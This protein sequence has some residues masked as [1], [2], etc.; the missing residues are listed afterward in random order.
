ML[1]ITGSG[2][3]GTSVLARFCHNMGY[4]T[5]GAWNH[6]MN[7]GMEDGR[8]VETSNAIEQGE[9]TA[10]VKKY[11]DT[12]PRRVVKD[13]RFMR[14][15]VTELWAERRADLQVLVCVRNMEH[16]SQ[17]YASTTTQDVNHLEWVTSRTHE[18]IQSYVELAKHQ[19]PVRFLAF[20]NFLNDYNTVHELL[21]WGGLPID[22]SIGELAW[23]GLVN[24]DMVHF[25]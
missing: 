24:K 23:N 25:R 17:S 3:C 6:D 16:V 2:R 21:E 15:K 5:G 4:V 1:V 10:D 22:Y 11:V 18:M 13:P 7:A 19:V 8:F 12:F 14:P 9:V 20:P